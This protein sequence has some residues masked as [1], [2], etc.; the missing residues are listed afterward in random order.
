MPLPPEEVERLSK[1]GPAAARL[2]LATSD[3]HGSRPDSLRKREVMTWIEA[4]EAQQLADSEQGREKR[5]E[6]AN[7]NARKSAESANRSARYAMYTAVVA[8]VAAAISIKD[9]LLA[10]A[11]GTP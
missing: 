3:V 4:A 8:I 5:E 1:I 7:S 9:Q 2:E 10:L 11:F 6:E